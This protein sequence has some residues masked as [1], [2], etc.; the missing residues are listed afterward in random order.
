MKKVWECKDGTKITY[1]LPN[2]IE[3]CEL[4]EIVGWG[5]KEVGGYGMIGRILKKAEPFIE[6]IEGKESWEDCINSRAL[7]DDLSD[8]ALALVQDELEPEVKKS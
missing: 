7:Y 8:L 4:Q 6:E 3:L 5:K 1:R 2:V